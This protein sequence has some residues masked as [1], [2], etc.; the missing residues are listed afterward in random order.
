MGVGAMRVG[1]MRV[2]AMRVAGSIVVILA[3]AV[4]SGLTTTDAS[5]S[6]IGNFIGRSA[7]GTADPNSSPS[8]AITVAKPSVLVTKR[9]FPS[10]DHEQSVMQAKWIAPTYKSGSNESVS[11]TA[12]AS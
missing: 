7:F 8:N 12:T 1:A 5:S 10:G 3:G 6:S 2:G 11:Y 9:M 4:C